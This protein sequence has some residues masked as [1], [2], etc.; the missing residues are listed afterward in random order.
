MLPLQNGAF[1]NGE[2]TPIT[3]DKSDIK[4]LFGNV[5]EIYSF[6]K[7]FSPHSFCSSF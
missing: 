7:V 5:N 6:H 2:T 1:E 3:L 4:T